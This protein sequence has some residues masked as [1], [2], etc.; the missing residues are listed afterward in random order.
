[1]WAFCDLS[2]TISISCD[3]FWVFAC[4][5][6][7]WVVLRQWAVFCDSGSSFPCYV[8]LRQGLV[9]WYFYFRD[10]IRWSGSCDLNVTFSF[11]RCAG[12]WVFC[13][14]LCQDRVWSDTISLPRQWFVICIIPVTYI[15]IL[16][17]Q[18]YLSN[19]CLWFFIFVSFRINEHLTNNVQVYYL[20]CVVAQVILYSLLSM[21]KWRL[22]AVYC[23]EQGSF[24]EVYHQWAVG[25]GALC[26]LSKL[27]NRGDSY[28]GQWS[29]SSND[30]PC[31]EVSCQMVLLVLDSVLKR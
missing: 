19:V 17:C 2:D 22:M 7:Q 4:V 16:C 24:S 6:R 18:N 25:S 21:S 3:Y 23:Q 14:A 26:H 8:V 11:S 5:L 27:W 15:G 13:P 20:W 28:Y 1:M 10:F 31:Y 12:I 9:E 29:L 30:V